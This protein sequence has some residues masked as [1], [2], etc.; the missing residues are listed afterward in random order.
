MFRLSVFPSVADFLSYVAP[1]PEPVRVPFSSSSSAVGCCFPRVEPFSGAFVRACVRPSLLY[2]VS[3]FAR[4]SLSSLRFILRLARES[5]LCVFEKGVVATRCAKTA[6]DARYSE[7]GKGMAAPRWSLAPRRGRKRGAA[8]G[9]GK[10]Q[11]LSHDGWCMCQR[12]WGSC[13]CAYIYSR[14]RELRAHVCVCVRVRE[15]AHTQSQEPAG[16]NDEDRRPRPG[17]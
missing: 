2:S 11:S 10:K 13:T 15:G 14:V 16:D 5:C 12:G 1:L 17:R 8:C 9:G 3:L 6:C 4:V 7:L